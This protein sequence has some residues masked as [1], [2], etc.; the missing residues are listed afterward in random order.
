MGLDRGPRDGTMSL[1]GNG[2][3]SFGQ[4]SSLG[5][6]VGSILSVPVGMFGGPIAGLAVK[7]AG[8]YGPGI[9]NAALG[10]AGGPAPLGPGGMPAPGEKSGSGVPNV[11]G[12]VFGSPGVGSLYDKASQLQAV[13]IP[14]GSMFGRNQT[15]M[16]P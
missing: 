14:D 6:T 5:S 16:G 10:L 3:P 13:G 15:Y 4:P 2:M 1:Q 7:E 12:G 9:A 8:K 11:G